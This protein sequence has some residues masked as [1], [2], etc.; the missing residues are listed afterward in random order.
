MD[1]HVIEAVYRETM[2][3]SNETVWEMLAWK[4]WLRCH[5]IHHHGRHTRVNTSVGTVYDIFWFS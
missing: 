2:I 4:E 3:P 5:H 1:R